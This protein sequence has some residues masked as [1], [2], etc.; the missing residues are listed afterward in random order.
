MKPFL[1]LVARPPSPIK[2]DEVSALLRYGR[3][4]EQDLEIIDLLQGPQP[5][6]DVSRYSGV[7]ISG[8]PYDYLTPPSR[9]SETQLLVE[10]ELG[11]ICGELVSED[12]PTLGL[13]YGLQALALAA[14]A[15][16][17]PEYSEDMQPMQISLTE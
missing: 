9:K 14:G 17:T 7:F 2:S 16:L 4:R 10:S 8:S 6:P 1:L 13:C 3:L 11:Q 5:I 12:I 15:T